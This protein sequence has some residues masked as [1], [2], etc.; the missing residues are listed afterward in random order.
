MPANAKPLKKWHLM[1][2][3]ISLKRWYIENQSLYFD[4]C[5]WESCKTSTHD[6][7]GSYWEM[8]D[9]LHNDYCPKE[10][11]QLLN[12]FGWLYAPS[13]SLVLFWLHSNQ[14]LWKMCVMSRLT[15]FRCVFF[16]RAHFDRV[17]RWFK[18][19]NVSRVT[20]VQGLNMLPLNYLV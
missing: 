5:T 18:K 7:S 3:I 12:L 1:A 6:L 19:N 20:R 15:P 9:H 4:V 11:G 10:I 16:Y 14:M 2:K 13:P 8:Q 17:K